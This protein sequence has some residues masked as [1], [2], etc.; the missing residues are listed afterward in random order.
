MSGSPVLVI[1]PHALDEV[2]GCGGTVA[3]DAG[4]G[5]KVDILVLMGDGSGR[6]AARRTAAGRAAELLGARPPRFAGFPENRSDTIP[7]L[8]LVG[9][10]ERALRELSPETV[11]VSPAGSLNLDHRRVFEAGVTAL[12]P[13][14]GLSVRAVYAYEILS[15]T[16]W[17]PRGVGP[18]FVPQ[19]FVDVSPFFALKLAALELY[20][21]E[22]RPFPHARSLEAVK[23]HAA[24]R[25]STIGVGY[26]EAFEVVREIG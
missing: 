14:P 5:A 11:Y 26:A 21:D 3:R 13:Q 6:D 4:T 2:L 25:G 8:E 15:S 17:A 20:G 1:A 22:M 7:L 12:R 23:A 24:Y 10:V 9:A 16:N 18:P 19:R